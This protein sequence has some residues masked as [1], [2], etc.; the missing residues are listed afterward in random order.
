[1]TNFSKPVGFELEP[2]DDA[3]HLTTTT[4]QPSYH[5][6]EAIRAQSHSAE[7]KLLDDIFWFMN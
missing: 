4:A 2:S 3:D 6:R 7:G 1:M 5:D